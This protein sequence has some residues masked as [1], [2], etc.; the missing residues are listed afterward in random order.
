MRPAPV[1]GLLFTSLLLVVTLLNPEAFDYDLGPVQVWTGSYVVYPLLGL[2]VIAGM[3]RRRGEAP[4]GPRV[5]GWVGAVLMAQAALF[6]LVG[7]ALLFARETMADLWPW[8]ITNGLAQFYGGPFLAYAW[9][10][11]AYA[12]KRNWAETAVVAPAMLAFTLSTVVV[13]AVH[14][15]L[16][17]AGD[18]EDWLWF[19]SFGLLATLFLVISVRA[20]P[21][22]L[23]GRD[24]RAI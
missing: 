8:P 4:P 12:R 9:C 11:W 14:D 6:A 19:G 21:A 13:S 1:A 24:A 5:P 16:F 15:E 22:L 7:V 10:S 18:V 3:H 2:L 20:V 23:P 17:S